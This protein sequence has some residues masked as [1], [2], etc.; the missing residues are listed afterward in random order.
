M[1]HRKHSTK[2]LTALLLTGLLT[3][4]TVVTTIPLTTPIEV[5]AGV[6]SGLPNKGKYK[7][8]M[9]STADVKKK[10]NKSSYKEYSK[11]F[12]EVYK[13]FKSQGDLATVAMMAIVKNAPYEPGYVEP[14]FSEDNIFG[15]ELPSGESTIQNLEDIEYLREWDSK[16]VKYGVMDGKQY[17]KGSC[18]I[19]MLGWTFDRRVNLCNK[20]FEVMETDEDVTPENLMKAEI[21]FMRDEFKSYCSSVMRAAKKQ[22]TMSNAAK[23]LM[24]KY[25]KPSHDKDEYIEKVAKDALNIQKALAK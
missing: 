25:V 20:Y 22:T 17:M 21:L 11:T 7:V 13:A 4:V 3:A 14:A 9:K 1:K 12:T 16:T 2:R 6:T 19:G 8:K 10:I 18:P 5:Q 23:H 15:F 24:E